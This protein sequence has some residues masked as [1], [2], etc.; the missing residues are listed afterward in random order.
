MKIFKLFQNKNREACL[1]FHSKF[2][3]SKRKE[4]ESQEQYEY[5]P[6]NINYTVP[7]YFKNPKDM[8]FPLLINGAPMLAIK[9]TNLN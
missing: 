6:F 8:N 7:K 5:L 4:N 1:I 3:F 9:V 2:T